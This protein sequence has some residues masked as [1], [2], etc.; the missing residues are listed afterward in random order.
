MRHNRWD[1]SG[2]SDRRQVEEGQTREGNHPKVTE[3]RTY[4]SIN[5][6]LL[7]EPL[8][9]ASGLLVRSVHNL[10]FHLKNNTFRRKC[11][12]KQRLWSKHCSFHARPLVG[13]AFCVMH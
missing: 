3:K 4:Q 10:F 12:E 5:E 6:T 2:Q 8:F 7:K 9:T 1:N 13:D 11:F